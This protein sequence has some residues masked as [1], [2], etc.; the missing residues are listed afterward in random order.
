M[1][2]KLVCDVRPV[3]AANHRLPEVTLP[4]A[5]SQVKKKAIFDCRFARCR[6]TTNSADGTVDQVACNQFN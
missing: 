3:L 5:A 1:L 2:T 6:G 4:P